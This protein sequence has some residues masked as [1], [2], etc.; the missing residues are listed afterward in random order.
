MAINLTDFD[1]IWASTSPL[2]P[3]AFSDNNYKQGWNFVGATPPARQMW[4]SYMKFSDEKQQ[5]IVNN[6][7]PL[8][9]G[10]MTGV[11]Y[12]DTGT[13]ARIQNNATNNDT[14]I[15]IYGGQGYDNGAY[16]ILNGKDRSTNGGSFGLYAKDD[17]N[18]TKSLFGKPDGTLKWNG[19]SIPERSYGII[20]VSTAG[21]NTY[22]F[23]IT[24]NG[25]VIFA[26]RGAS[27]SCH[28]VTYWDSGS[29]KIFSTGTDPI[30]ITKS[31]NSNSVTITNAYS[32][33][34]AI[35]II[36]GGTL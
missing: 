17:N 4:D 7:L 19:T 35:K 26:K 32:S 13:E 28:M 6:F 16:L 3:Y 30:T 2:T 11:L 36:N 29:T 5:Y 18:G 25:A 14:N 23:S 10:T 27:C 8:A 33:A 22:T 15:G 1:K 21:E 20:L 24:A 34:I 31:A 12:F 9:G